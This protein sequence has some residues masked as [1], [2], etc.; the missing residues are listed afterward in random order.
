V[1]VLATALLLYSRLP[2]PQGGGRDSDDELTASEAT[3]SSTAT[4]I[5]P[6]AWPWSRPDLVARATPAAAPGQETL[7]SHLLAFRVGQRQIDDPTTDGWST[8]QWSSLTQKQLQHL[9]AQ[10]GKPLQIDS[11]AH[12]A[13]ESFR[14]QALVPEEWSTVFDDG[15]IAVRR[16]PRIEARNPRHRGRDGLVQALRD[17]VTGAGGSG[18]LHAH[19]KTYGIVAASGGVTTRVH[20]TLSRDGYA[21]GSDWECRWSRTG[22]RSTPLLEEIRVLE[23]EEVAWQGPLFGECTTSV[24]GANDAFPSQF[25]PGI[26]HWLRS[27]DISI[28]PDFEGMQGI[29]IGDVDGDALEDVYLCQG[30]GLPNRLFKQK[31][32]G[33]AID[34]TDAA[35][36]GG[37]RRRAAHC[38]SIWTTTGTKT[39]WSR[40]TPCSW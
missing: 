34:I 18:E 17:F 9:A 37:S 1:L 10:C 24:L 16:A 19:A 32:D 13:A 7:P 15:R 36:V 29:A 23:L 8:E 4:P 31:K 3:A 2:Q 30:G 40:R 14:C 6:E 28:D 11:L 5:D 25:V 22:P 26:H 20:F 35:G 39:S 33:T 27:I 12:L 38:S 21:I